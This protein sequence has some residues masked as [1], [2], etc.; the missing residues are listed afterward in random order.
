[1]QNNSSFLSNTIDL[2]SPYRRHISQRGKDFVICE[3][4]NLKFAEPFKNHFNK[5]SQ[6]ICYQ[7]GVSGHIRPHCSQIRHLQPQIR[8]TEQKTGKS[9]SKPSKPHH[10]FQ[11]QGHYPQRDS[12]SCHHYGK[13]GHIKAECFKVK[14]HKSK[15]KQTNGGLVNTMK[16][17]LVRLIN[18]D[19]AHTPASQVENV[20]V[21]KDGTI[22]PLRGSRLT[23]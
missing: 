14:L 5:R 6:P 13:Y 2:C 16:N 10:A 20:W 18:W 22:H 7:C 3:N 23:Q 4:A 1:M 8:K 17:V 21:R 15:K 12:S 11:Q 19:M 9:S